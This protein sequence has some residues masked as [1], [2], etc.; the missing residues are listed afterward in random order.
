MADLDGASPS[1][2]QQFAVVSYISGPLGGFL[3]RLR[4]RLVPGC[5]LQP[6]ITLLP[7]RSVPHAP[8]LLSEELEDLAA[9]IPAFEVTLGE[10][11]IFPITDVVYL[12]VRAGWQELVHSYATLSAGKFRAR[13]AFA[14]HPHVTLAQHTAAGVSPLETARQARLAWRRWK[15]IRSFPVET[16][17]FVRNVESGSWET[18]SEH[19]LSPLELP[20]TA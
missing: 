14:F 7:P 13:E 11:E 12:S 17:S 9:R 15:G 16:L 6:H 18:V 4:S 8:A 2:P 20:R 10:V 5:S 1:F 3:S 19:P